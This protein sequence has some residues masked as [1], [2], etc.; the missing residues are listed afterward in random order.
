MKGVTQPYRRALHGRL[1]NEI[2]YLGVT[3]PI[4]DEYL[5]KTPAILPVGNNQPVTAW[6]Q[7]M[8]TTSEPA[9]EAKCMRNDDANIQIQARVSFNANSGNYEHAENIMDLVLARLF[10]QATDNSFNLPIENPFNIW[11]LTKESTRNINYQD[12]TARIWMQN[13][14]LRAS[15]S[16]S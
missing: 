8:N 12:N 7:L 3:I 4:C 13:I 10:D 16:Q 6:I 14:I 11:K 9:N 2:V 5:N 1:D 15:I